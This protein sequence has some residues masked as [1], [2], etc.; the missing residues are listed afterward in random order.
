L[1][2]YTILDTTGAEVSGATHEFK[3]DQHGFQAALTGT[4]ALTATVNIDVSNDG[5]T[6]ITGRWVF[7]LSGST[8]VVEGFSSTER[9]GYVKARTSAL[10]GTGAR[11]VVSVAD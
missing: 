11:V 7:T 3:S 8:A 1:N 6:W 9:W 2:T 5:V 4:G 10:T